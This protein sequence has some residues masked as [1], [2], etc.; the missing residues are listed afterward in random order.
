MK[1]FKAS[2]KSH[3][4]F[5][6]MLFLYGLT[7][8]FFL[9]QFP[10]MHSDEAWLS[11][12]SQTVLSEGRFDL[13][14]PFFDL[15]PRNPHAIKVIFVAIQAFTI[16]LFGHSLFSMRMISFVAGLF[17]LCF[18]YRIMLKRFA[19]KTFALLA[20]SLLALDIQFIYASHMARQESIL[21][22]IS[23]LAYSFFIRTNETSILDAAL[24]AL[25]LSIGIGIHPN[26]FIISI[27][28][29]LMLTYRFLKGKATFRALL[30]FIAVLGGAAAFFIVLSLGMDPGFIGNYAAYGKTLGVTQ[31]L[32]SKLSQIRFFYQKLFYQVSGTYY[33]PDIRVQLLAM[34]PVSIWG[35]VRLLKSKGKSFS[36]YPL[37]AIIGIN[38]GYLLVGRYNQ[39]S[40]VFLFPWFYMLLAEILYSFRKERRA[41]LALFMAITLSI[42]CFS[43]GIHPGKSYSSYLDKISE[44]VDKDANVLANLNTGY[45]FKPDNLYDYRNLA[46]LKESSL[47]FD[48]YIYNN[49]IEFILY[50]EEMDI[51]WNTRPVYNSLYGNPSDYY[52]AMNNFLDKSCLLVGTFTDDTYPVRIVRLMGQKERTLKIYKVLDR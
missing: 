13:T 31:S 49:H 4:A 25:I 42:T 18:F 50:P 46:Y 21:L 23:L 1:K 27:P 35:L 33:T 52:E 32:V 37:L 28:F 17:S 16:N 40:I 34:I 7:G 11:G 15:Y 14:E 47:S 51:I 12:L 10:F 30:I 19:N 45:Y 41:I 5:L 2:L 9:D 36:A 44:W 26:S 24:L 29:A 8:I 20:T 6:F 3:R 22:L 48:D 38:I 43:I 39:T